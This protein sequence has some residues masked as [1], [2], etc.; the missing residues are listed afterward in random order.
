MKELI[1]NYE[2]ILILIAFIVIACLFISKAKKHKDIN[3]GI[4]RT[5]K[6]LRK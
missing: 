5:S 2:G 4:L 1:N 3:D 6:K